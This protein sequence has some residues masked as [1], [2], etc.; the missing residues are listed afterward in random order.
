MHLHDY[1]L[2][3]P[4]TSLYTATDYTCSISHCA[5]TLTSKLSSTNGIEHK[6]FAWR[7]NCFEL[8]I[9]QFIFWPDFTRLKYFF[10][11]KI[12]LILL[13]FLSVGANVEK[14]S[15]LEHNERNIYVKDAVNRHNNSIQKYL[16]FYPIFLSAN[17]LIDFK[18]GGS[19][20]RTRDFFK[21]VT[22]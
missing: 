3:S 2:S 1:A 22:S 13:T 5:T 17:F 8:F 21:Y 19:Q 4:L 14:L 20:F 12:I 10:V 15:L 7:M 16:I 9:F 6:T 18:K 11:V